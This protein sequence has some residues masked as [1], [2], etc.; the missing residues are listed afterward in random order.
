[1]PKDGN[2]DNQR[3]V[4]VT[5]AC[6]SIGRAVAKEFLREGHYSVVINGAD[7][8][9]L[10]Q[11][12]KEILKS[13]PNK[14]DRKRLTIFAGDVSQEGVSKELINKAAKTYGRVDVLVN[15]AEVIYSPQRLLNRLGNPNDNIMLHPPTPYFT[16][17]EYEFTDE[18]LSGAYLCSKE[19]SEWWISEAKESNVNNKIEGNKNNNDN[20]KKKQKRNNYSI[21]NISHCYNS[22]PESAEEVFTDSKSGVDLF[23]YSKENTRTLTKT[24]A[25]ALL[26][27]GIRVNAIIPGIISTESRQ[28][29]SPRSE[30][31]EENSEELLSSAAGQPQDVAKAVT[32]LA[33]DHAS[34]I[35]G[36]ILYVDG[37][38]S[39]SRPM[40]FVEQDLERY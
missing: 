7:E 40:R 1:M 35:T 36:S 6:R 11:A 39:L 18:S 14:D 27:K 25:L 29:K 15:N 13:F 26:D 31:E 4:I 30:N 9:I 16:L 20:N 21:I 37:G 3:V 22:L 19:A 23:T 5:G 28:E 34:Y 12:A 8:V 24:S 17:E 2:N 38:L 32:F 33:S 10:D